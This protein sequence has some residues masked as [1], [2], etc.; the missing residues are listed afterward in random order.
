MTFRAISFN[1]LPSASASVAPS[2]RLMC[3]LARDSASQKIPG[4][5]SARAGIAREAWPLL[6]F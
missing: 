4:E 5:M 3:F 6:F 1:P 2:L